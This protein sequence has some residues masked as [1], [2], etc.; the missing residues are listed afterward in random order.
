MS[1]SV[2]L[3]LVGKE[4]LVARLV[5]APTRLMSELKGELT[6]FAMALRDDAGRRAGK[7]SGRLDASI[8]ATVTALGSTRMEVLLQTT[9]VPYAKIQEEGGS[10]PPR[11]INT[12][13]ASALAFMWMG[14][15][16]AKGDT[17]FFHHVNWPGARIPAKHYILGSLQNRRAEFL[18]ICQDA[19]RRSLQT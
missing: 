12:T 3:T 14:S 16:A 17:A 18:S 8:T 2:K 11:T 6:P 15:G 10:I 19:M 13:K 1:G 9:G 7:R 5:G 4:A